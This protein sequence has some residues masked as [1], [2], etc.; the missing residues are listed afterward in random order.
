MGATTIRAKIKAKDGVTIR[1]VKV[2]VEE[3][4]E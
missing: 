1:T 4:S 2:M 3:Q